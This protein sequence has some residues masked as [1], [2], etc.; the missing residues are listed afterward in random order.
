MRALS[1]AAIITLALTAATPPAFAAGAADTKDTKD[2]KPAK[3]KNKPKKKKP[4]AATA[5]PAPVAIDADA[6]AQP[7]PAPLPPAPAPA[8]SQAATAPAAPAHEEAAVA[9]SAGGQGETPPDRADQ[10]VVR[11]VIDR[12]LFEVEAGGEAMGRHFDYNDGYSANLRSYNLFPAPAVAVG[13]QVYPF[14][15][16]KGI[17]GDIGVAGSYS[18]LLFVQSTVGSSQL[19]TTS[20][21]YWGGV[22]VRI[23]A[24]ETVLLGA[25]LSYASTSFTFS[26]ASS[27]VG[28]QLPN[29]TYQAIRP[30]VDARVPFGRFALLGTVAFRAV[31]SSDGLSSR[32]RSPSINGV[33][34]EVGGAAKIVDGLEARLLGSYERYFYSF[35]P[36]PG[37]VYV[38]GGALDQ[39]FG[40]RL[41]VAYLF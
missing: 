36:A 10:K 34:A 15:G 3:N 13:G 28:A 35:G 21:S 24:G 32:F 41:T 40:A 14:A 26:S 39:F 22:R 2:T 31:V 6:P 25:S 23:H 33:E 30:A 11:G 4:A 18:Q 19:P 17:L 9:V 5:A 8:A 12:E 20:S 7:A 37:D 29:E 1:V 27:S 16:T 38:A